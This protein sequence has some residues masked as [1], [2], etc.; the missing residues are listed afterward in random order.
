[1]RNLKISSSVLRDSHEMQREADTLHSY[2]HLTKLKFWG[3]R[4]N[5][6]DIKEIIFSFNFLYIMKYLL[7]QKSMNF[8]F[9]KKYERASKNYVTILVTLKL[10]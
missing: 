7:V 6:F 5:I 4:R 9:R 1:M 2:R 8:F 10:Q 3:F